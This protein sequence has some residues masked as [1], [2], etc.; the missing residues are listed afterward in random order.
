VLRSPTV[1]AEALHT[2]AVT[3]ILVTG[4]VGHSTAYL[5]EAITA[6]RVYRDTV[7]AGR[8]EAAVLAEILRRH[9]DVPAESLLIESEATNCGR[10]AELSLRLLAARRVP[11]GSIVVVQDPTMQRRT[12]AAFEQWRG[13]GGPGLRSHAP[14]VPVVSR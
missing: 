7:T 14:F 4:G 12:H 10:N 13:P 2:G 6:H 1:A 9:L 3:Q 11:V 5:R 8:T